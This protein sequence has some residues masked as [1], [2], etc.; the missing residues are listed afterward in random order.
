MQGELGEDRKNI[1]LTIKSFYESFKNRKNPPA[2]ILK[3][4]VVNGSILDKSEILRRIKIIRDG[5]IGARILPKIYLLHGKFTD[6]EMNEIY[7]HPKIKSMISL[8]KGEG[9][10]RPLLEF[11]LVNKPIIATKWSGS[12]RFSKRGKILVI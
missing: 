7:N 2:L 12:C 8:T 3:C 4:C 11:C 5:M 10:G 9:F 1:G 6:S